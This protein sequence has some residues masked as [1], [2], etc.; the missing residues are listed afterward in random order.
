MAVGEAAFEHA[1]DDNHEAIV[2]LALSLGL[3]ALLDVFVDGFGCWEAEEGREGGSGARSGRD[4]RGLGTRAERIF[5]RLRRCAFSA[6]D[7]LETTG[8]REEGGVGQD[9]PRRV[10]T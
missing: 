7:G 9:A 10:R 8:R 1:F 3:G 2:D 6:R 5:S 4:L